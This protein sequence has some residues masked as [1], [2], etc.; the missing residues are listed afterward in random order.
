MALKCL[1][2]EKKKQNVDYIEPIERSY[3]QTQATCSKLYVVNLKA[4]DRRG[5]KPYYILMYLTRQRD[6]AIDSNDYP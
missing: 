3:S 5:P 2:F 1:L 4:R 6:R